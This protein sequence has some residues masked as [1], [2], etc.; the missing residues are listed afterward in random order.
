[1]TNIESPLEELILFLDSY[2]SFTEMDKKLIL[3]HSIIKKIKKGTCFIEEGETVD[4]VGF[5]LKGAFRF[6]YY[7]QEGKEVTTLFFEKNNFLTYHTK[8]LENSKSPVNLEAILDSY[9]I[10]FNK[11]SWNT[12]SAEIKNWNKTISIISTRFLEDLAI[13]QRNIIN[14]NAKVSYSIFID[15]YPAIYNKIPLSHISSFLGITQSSL[16]RI[17]K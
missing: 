8:F 11:N 12:L 7:N 1:M 16:S 5:I 13:F 15:K 4:K 10:V 6:M 14:K 9:I 17:R 3:E 2:S